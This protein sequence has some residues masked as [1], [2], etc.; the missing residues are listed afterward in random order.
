MSPFGCVIL[1]FAVGFIVSQVVALCR[2]VT[3]RTSREDWKRRAVDAEKQLEW[4]HTEMVRVGDP[5]KWSTRR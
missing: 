3:L 5:V 4:E 1:G 2:N